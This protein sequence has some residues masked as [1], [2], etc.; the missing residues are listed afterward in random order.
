MCIRDRGYLERLV[1]EFPKSK[2]IAMARQA[3]VRPE[4]SGTGKV[5]PN[6]EG[7]TIDDFA[8]NLED[9]RGKVV[10]LDFYGFW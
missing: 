6:F 8:F 3:L 10:V 5:A 2:S 4:D 7:K 9:Y 1:A